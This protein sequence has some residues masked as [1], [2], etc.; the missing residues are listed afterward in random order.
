MP[1]KGVPN[2]TSVK[3]GLRALAEKAGYTPGEFTM[4]R[5]AE[6]AQYLAQWH[7]DFKYGRVPPEFKG[8]T[9]QQAREKCTQETMAFIEEERKWAEF[10]WPKM[11]STE[12]TGADGADLFPDITDTERAARIVA[13][14]ESARARRINGSDDGGEAV[15]APPGSAD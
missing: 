6:T 14:L 15:D 8:Q 1:A 10:F 2:P 12:I 3:R 11:K 4:M 5:M 13:I 7:D 9:I